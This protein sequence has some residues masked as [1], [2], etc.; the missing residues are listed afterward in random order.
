MKKEQIEVKIISNKQVGLKYFKITFSSATIAAKAVPGQFVM[1]KPQ[2]GVQPLL[3][4][5]LGVHSVHGKNIDLLYEVVG[6]ATLILSQ[7]KPDEFISLIGPLGRG[8]CY[9]GRSILV[10]G[11]MG[12][13]PL[14]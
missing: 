5:P 3:R 12:V 6:P 14:V 1:V 9:E 8:F 13:A 10:A 4:R 7:K 2:A 11:G